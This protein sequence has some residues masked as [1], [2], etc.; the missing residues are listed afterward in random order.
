METRNDIAITT[1]DLD[2]RNEDEGRSAEWEALAWRNRRWWFRLRRTARLTGGRCLSRFSIN[3]FVCL[4][5]YYG[6]TQFHLIM[7]FRCFIMI[8]INGLFICFLLTSVLWLWMGWAHSKWIKEIM[9]FFLQLFL[10][11]YL[12]ISKC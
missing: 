5:R 6:E 1:R 3:F 8:V 2:Q 10:K 9:K 7:K 12:Y 11:F 4:V